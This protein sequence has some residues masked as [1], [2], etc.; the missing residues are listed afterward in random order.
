MNSDICQNVSIKKERRK[1]VLTIRKSVQTACMGYACVLQ[2]HK[3]SDLSK[4]G[5]CKNKSSQCQ[6]RIPKE[7]KRQSQ[8]W[9]LRFHDEMPL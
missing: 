8:K 9:E 5:N 7:S 2:A 6:L 4:Q 1:Y 3:L